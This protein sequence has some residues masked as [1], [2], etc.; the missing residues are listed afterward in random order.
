[1][2]NRDPF[3]EPSPDIFLQVCIARHLK[4][5]LGACYGTSTLQDTGVRNGIMRCQISAAQELILNAYPACWVNSS[6]MT[7]NKLTVIV[8]TFQSIKAL[9]VQNYFPNGN[10]YSL[11]HSTALLFLKLLFQE[12]IKSKAA[13]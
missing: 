1:M 6:D 11:I 7:S 2:S 3:L 12:K 4:L 13:S 9:L 10:T 5:E 8:L